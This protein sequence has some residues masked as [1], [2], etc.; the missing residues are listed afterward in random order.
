MRDRLAR[1]RAARCRCARAPGMS[2]P[3]VVIPP[4]GEPDAAAGD[5]AAGADL[6][7]VLVPW[8]GLADPRPKKRGIVTALDSASQFEGVTF[9]RDVQY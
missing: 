4:I 5:G 1:S 9:E 7:A 8:D 3:E 6:S 2:G